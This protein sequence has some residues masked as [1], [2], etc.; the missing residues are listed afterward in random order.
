MTKVTGL[1]SRLA[2][3]DVIFLYY[4]APIQQFASL[5]A[6]TESKGLIILLRYEAAFKEC[7]HGPWP[8][9]IQTAS[10]GAFTD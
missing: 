10:G 3:A 6:K 2:S 9:M 5:R 1:G 8:L 7:V 4:H